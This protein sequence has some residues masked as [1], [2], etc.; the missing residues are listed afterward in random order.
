MCSDVD[1]YKV[2]W[3]HE[4]QEELGRRNSYTDDSLK[5]KQHLV[6]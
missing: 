4:E 1:I 5:H 3:G 2:E 6:I